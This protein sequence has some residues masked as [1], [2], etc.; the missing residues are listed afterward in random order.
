VPSHGAIV[1]ERAGEVLRV[2]AER[3]R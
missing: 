2:V 1:S 3:L